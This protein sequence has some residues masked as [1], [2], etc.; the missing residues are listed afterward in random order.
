MYTKNRSQ[1]YYNMKK[2][3]IRF[4]V[5]EPIVPPRNI[6]CGVGP[7]L[8]IT[9]SQKSFLDIFLYLFLL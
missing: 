6:N 7:A 2:H 1:N 3:G 5:I 9:K 8:Q 4:G